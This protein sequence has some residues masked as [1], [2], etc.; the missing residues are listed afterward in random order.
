MN[1]PRPPSKVLDAKQV[2]YKLRFKV[3]AAPRVA[4][5][6]YNPRRMYIAC[7]FQEQADSGA[8]HITYSDV[9]ARWVSYLEAFETDQQNVIAINIG[10]E[11]VQRNL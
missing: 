6:W 7:T 5:S 11:G 4:Q 3:V 9:Q 8:K 10:S 1:L 2:F